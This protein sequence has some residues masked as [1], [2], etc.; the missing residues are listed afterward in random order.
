MKKG[1][2]LLCAMLF[3][4]AAAF[5]V[6]CAKDETHKLT[7]VPAQEATCT[8]AGHEQYYE[9][10]E[11]G[12][13]F[14][15]ALGKKEI[16]LEDI[17]TAALGHDLHYVEAK[18]A[19][20]VEEGNIAYYD[21]S[22]C[23]E[24]FADEAGTQAL[25]ESPFIAKIDH[26]MT[27]VERK[28]PTYEEDGWIAHYHCSQCDKNYDNSFGDNEL[29]EEEVILPKIAEVGSV[30]LEMTVYEN[31]QESAADF[32]NET[33][34][35]ESKNV[36]GVTITATVNGD[37]VTFTKVYEDDYIVRVG[38]YKGEISFTRGTS[39]YTLRVAYDFAIN[40]SKSQSGTASVDL[41]EAN[42]ENHTIVLSES[43]LNTGSTSYA[44]ATLGL[45][46][47]EK[48]STKTAVRFTLRWLGNCTSYGTDLTNYARLGVRMAE[49]KGICV[50]VMRPTDSPALQV[51]PLREEGYV[52]STGS[53]V[54][55]GYD[56]KNGG[57]YDFVAEAV[58]GSGLEVAVVRW[59]GTITLYAQIN[60][61]WISLCSTTCDPVAESDIR[62][63]VGGHEW[64][65]SQITYGELTWKEEL[66]ATETEAGYLAH[67]ALADIMLNEDGEMM[68]EEDVVLPP[69]QPHESVTFTVY[70]RK[71]ATNSLL[72]GSI[73][74]TDSQGN[75]IEGTIT[76][77]Q[78]T[79]S[80]VPRRT[81]TIEAVTENGDIYDGSVQIG[82]ETSYTFESNQ[83]SLQYRFATISSTIEAVGGSYILDTSAINNKHHII[84]V[85]TVWGPSAT[86]YATTIDYTISEELA[87]SKYAIASFWVKNTGGSFSNTTRFGVMMTDSDGVAVTVFPNTG[88]VG[89]RLQ[90]YEFYQK[91]RQSG[92]P[93]SDVFNGWH[94]DETYYA[95]VYA[96]LLNS[97]LH[98]QVVRADTSI[99]MY[100]E[101]GGAWYLIGEA[102]CDSADLTAIKF[103]VLN[104]QWQ[105]YDPSF[106]ILTYVEESEPT[107]D[108]AG[109]DAHYVWTDPYT[110]T[111]Y[112]FLSGGVKTTAEAIAR[113]N[114]AIVGDVTLT[115]NGYKDGASSALSGDLKAVMGAYE[116][117]G[118]AA[119]GTATLSGLRAGTWQ[120]TLDD[121]YYGEITVAEGTTAY[122]VTLQYRWATNTSRGGTATV[123]LSRM[124]EQ[125]RTIVMKETT[126]NTG[127]SAWAE[128]TLNLSDEVKTSTNVTVEFTVSV[129]G[130]LNAYSR[131]GVAMAERKGVFT[132]AAGSDLQIIAMDPNNYLGIFDGYDAL[133]KD[134]LSVVTTAL[135]GEGLKVKAERNGGSITMYFY[136][137]GTW[138]AMASTSCS[139]NAAT[140]IR[141]CVGGFNVN[142]WTF[143]D[144]SYSVNA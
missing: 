41:S 77:G 113:S 92:Q 9:C 39:S 43:S 98:I 32:D 82:E 21:C 90:T 72:T 5:A 120:L 139:A 133:H 137:A 141:L 30:T 60:S 18:D 34:T 44:E 142:E 23:D 79:L 50:C 97:R 140:D 51:F 31:G 75:K 22:R 112:Y 11:C 25:T 29:S 67:W 7:L 37:T 114:A 121:D 35:L 81:Y 48:A 1:K 111:Q 63:L 33:V 15:D 68:N 109:A 6:G 14:S 20:C 80:N 78:V 19:S 143:S 54:F 16:S 57:Y 74:L 26:D 40:T 52:G 70:G 135:Q 61:E 87:N 99:K 46:A 27:I 132:M 24:N 126:T 56:N 58:K 101:L 76:E 64:E 119:D 100:A 4:I 12:K 62:L 131:F 136:I 84:E 129:S 106:G 127:V 117:T 8:Q 144:I 128:A 108:A 55:D 91:D 10:S 85:K 83:G 116:I 96:A 94:P 89:T 69:T 65:F 49:E 110:T 17:A 42:S 13:L 45:S 73:T 86:N 53:G 3:A 88:D 59:G 36:D 107:A 38:R 102:T 2:L 138:T 47:E 118:V 95:A 122:T 103:L 71:D 124:N 28:D 134:Y 66:Y 93:D 115:V 105:I 104:G 125:N 123:D 130:T